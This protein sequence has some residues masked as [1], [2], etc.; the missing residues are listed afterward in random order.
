[1]WLKIKVSWHSVPFLLFCFPPQIPSHNYFAESW[2]YFISEFLKG[3]SIDISLVTEVFF[4]AVFTAVYN[5]QWLQH[6][7]R[8]LIDRWEGAVRP[9]PPQ[10][11]LAFLSL[12][13]FLFCFLQGLWVIIKPQ[14]CFVGVSYSDCGYGH[15]SLQTVT[16]SAEQIVAAMGHSSSFSSPMNVYTF[17]AHKA[18]VPAENGGANRQCLSR[19]QRPAVAPLT[20]VRRLH[21]YILQPC[22]MN[23]NVEKVVL[24]LSCRGSRKSCLYPHP[25]CNGF[26]L[27]QEP[28][29]PFLPLLFLMTASQPQGLIQC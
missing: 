14:Q 5:L 12:F 16:K 25:P 13:C 15:I 3:K 7:Q 6:L 9:P 28:F 1:M 11:F 27:F 18:N 10:D 29:S 21:V 22:F 23:C 4:D 2:V 26:P 24:L 19:C 8:S 20:D 17:P